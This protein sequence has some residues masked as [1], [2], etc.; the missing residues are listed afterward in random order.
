[1]LV[2]RWACGSTIEPRS[3]K[4]LLAKHFGAIDLFVWDGLR[5]TPPLA[6]SVE[7]FAACLPFLP[8]A[9]RSLE[10]LRPRVVASG[11]D[12]HSSWLCQR[13]ALP[14][15]FLLRA[16]VDVIGDIPSGV[17]LRLKFLAPDRARFR[18]EGHLSDVVSDTAELFLSSRLAEARGTLRWEDVERIAIEVR[19]DLEQPVDVRISDVR[20]SAE[21]AWLSPSSTGRTSAHLREGYDASYYHG[22]PGYTQYRENRELRERVNVHR[23]WA[24]LLAPAPERVVDVGSGRGELAE[25]LMA[26][27]ADVTLLDYSPAAMEFA[28]RLIGDSSQAH[29]VVDDAANLA[30]HVAPGSQDAIFMTDF[31]E[32]L[33]VDELRIVLR[34]CRQVL[35]PDGALIIHTP[36]RYSGAVATAKAIHGLHVNL[37]EID[38]LQALLLE[39]FGVVDVFTWN[40]FERFQERG[41]CIDLFALAHPEKPDSTHPLYATEDDGF[42]EARRTAWV[43]ERPLL[44][45]HFILDA[46]IDVSPLGAEGELEIAFLTTTGEYVARAVREFSQ[47]QTLPV[48]VRLAS[49]LLAPGSPSSWEAVERIVIT[50][51]SPR[52]ERV[53]LAVN[54]VHFCASDPEY[55]RSRHG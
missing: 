31:V 47:L 3:L 8:Y 35:T 43:F 20:I 29:F 42:G 39:T 10:L 48:S 46:T 50:A 14:G 34:A 21:A 30:T 40:G 51:S 27:G 4:T 18:I 54:D 26:R 22:M 38:T 7:L 11:P 23:A 1:V 55:S 53:E 16:T 33:S 28:K 5:R 13:P 2:L 12:W 17:D 36:E 6:G 25:H 15:R 49:E 44:P 9:T 41:H 45:A 32:H 52:G 19:T 37:F 24:L